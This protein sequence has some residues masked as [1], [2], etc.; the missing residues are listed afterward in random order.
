VLGVGEYAL[1]GWQLVDRFQRFEAMYVA[2][3]YLSFARLGLPYMG[4]GRN[5]H[6]YK[7]ANHVS[8]V[9]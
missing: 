6:P 4:V 8:L 2:L 3:K 7:G 1:N 9:R 5:R